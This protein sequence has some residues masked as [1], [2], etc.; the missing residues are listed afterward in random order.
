M[1]PRLVN[2]SRLLTGVPCWALHKVVWYI[3][4]HLAEGRVHNLGN[5]PFYFGHVDIPRSVLGQ[6]VRLGNSLLPA[7]TKNSLPFTVK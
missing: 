7:R 6:Q 3:D 2:T 4:S 5:I 1:A